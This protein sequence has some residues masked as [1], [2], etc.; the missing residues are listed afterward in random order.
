MALPNE[1]DTLR[2]G[3]AN[4]EIEV[5]IEESEP[6]ELEIVDDTPKEDKGRKP[7]PEG[8]AEPSDEEMEEYSENVKR[9]I[10]KMKH[11]LHDER[12]A[13]EA[14]ARERD[15]A[16]EYAKRIFDEKKA[17]ESRYVQGEDAFIGQ[18]KEKADLA[19]LTAKKEY[20][21]AYEL[22]DPDAMADA[23]EKMAVIANER[24]QAEAWS[25]QSAQRKET[26]GQQQQAVVQS[27]QPSR[28]SVPEPDPDA[29]DWAAK[30][31]WFGANGRMTNMAYAIHDELVAEGID[32]LTDADTYYKKLNSEM[33]ASFPSHDWGDAPKKKPT[34]VVAPVVRTSKTARRVTLTQSQVAVARRM[35][36]TPLQY[37]IELAK[38]S[39]N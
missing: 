9:R 21:A 35:G 10:A 28:P 15:A 16:V 4:D 7:L 2:K 34:S 14:A 8:E 20:K 13:K 39:E 17:L 23:Q 30:N 11:G 36:I 25:R 37:A 27:Q 24:Q 18:A 6:V 22:G 33:R 31:K 29:K 19:M 3:T 12:R 38:L 26:A 5:H 32:P 1:E